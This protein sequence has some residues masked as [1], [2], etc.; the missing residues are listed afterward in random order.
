MNLLGSDTLAGG[1]TGRRCP[2]KGGQKHAWT[3]ERRIK[4][5]ASGTAGGA[6]SLDRRAVSAGPP[7]RL[8]TCK[9]DGA[10]AGLMSGAERR[11]NVVFWRCGRWRA[12]AV[13]K[14]GLHG[15]TAKGA[16]VDRSSSGDARLAMP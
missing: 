1:T 11:A 13:G 12:E 14:I 8:H 3:R 2:R 9:A 7:W 16:T 5:V 10:S 4:A 15:A 6:R